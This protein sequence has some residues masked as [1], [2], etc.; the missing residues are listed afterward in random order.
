MTPAEALAAGTVLHGL[1]RHTVVRAG[2]ATDMADCPNGDRAVTIIPEG[3]S[4]CWS[5]CVSANQLARSV[6]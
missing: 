3:K 1:R 2:C 5:V 4:I 6:A